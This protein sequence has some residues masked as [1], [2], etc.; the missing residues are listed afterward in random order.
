MG[1]AD[2]VVERQK[3]AAAVYGPETLPALEEE[4]AALT[5]SARDELARQ[6]FGA[7][8]VDATAYLNLRYEGTN[9]AIMIDAPADGDYAGRLSRR[10]RREFGFDLS[11]RDIMV[12]D[13]RVRARGRTTGLRRVAISAAEHPTPESLE[14]VPCYSDQ[15]WRDTP[16]FDLGQLKAGHRISG[17]ALI[18]HDTSTLL[19]ESGCRADVTPY[20]DVRI[21]VG[22]SRASHVP[23][24]VDPV[25]L[26]IFSNL[27]ISIAEQMGRMLQKTAISTNIKER[28]DFSC[29]LFDPTGDLVAN[30][31]HVPVHLGAM[32]AAV[33]AQ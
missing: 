14:T 33:K 30:A 28:L 16:V 2:V 19:V 29:A 12:D 6:G 10:Y 11:E 32:S 7:D 27:F 20:G 26:A 25:Q 31:P 17:P 22:G 5:Q 1:L 24:R 4:I 9:T 13:I 18:V 15:G 3:P 8:H 21:H 23:T